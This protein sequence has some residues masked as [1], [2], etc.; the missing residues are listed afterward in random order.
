MA[1]HT[2]AVIKYG[3]YPLNDLL[4]KFAQSIPNSRPHPIVYDTDGYVLNGQGVPS[5]DV[6]EDKRHFLL[7]PQFSLEGLDTTYFSKTPGTE[8]REVD[9]L[10][11]S[12]VIMKKRGPAENRNVIRSKQVTVEKALDLHNQDWA[13]SPRDLLKRELSRAETYE[14]L[15]GK[16][17]LTD[18]FKLRPAYVACSLSTPDLA[19][20][21]SFKGFTGPFSRFSSRI[22]V[23]EE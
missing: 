12:V 5:F 1:R 11:S 21:L 22:K 9:E 8:L 14:T 6:P 19:Y 18:R 4:L 20:A 15:L 7:W 13:L 2:L 23:R 10:V 17:F 16:G 3:D